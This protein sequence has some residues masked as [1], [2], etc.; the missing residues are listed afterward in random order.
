MNLNFLNQKKSTDTPE[1]ND[2]D[3]V[4]PESEQPEEKDAPTETEVEI[5]ET[6]AAF[7]A[8]ITEVAHNNPQFDVKQFQTARRHWCAANGCKPNHVEFPFDPA[9]PPKFSDPNP[10][11]GVSDDDTTGA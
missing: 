8:Y 9:N 2:N 11:D 5:S 4:K 10:E 1:T 3:L 6:Q 7:N